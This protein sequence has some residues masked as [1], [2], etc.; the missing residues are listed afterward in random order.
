M[1]ML[2]R[3]VVGVFLICV[4]CCST[5]CVG[6]DTILLDPEEQ[7]G[8][9]VRYFGWDTKGM[10][11]L[12]DDLQ[13]AKWLYQ[14]TQANIMR[15]PIRP[16]ASKPDGSVV[17][18][19]EIESGGYGALIKS[20][21]MAKQVQP[22]VKIF[23]ST[24]LLGEDTFPTWLETDRRGK[25]FEHVVKQPNVE[26]LAGLIAEYFKHLAAEGIKI[27]FLGLNN[28]FGGALTPDD[29]VEL[30]E[31]VQTNL[32]E[33][34]LPDQFK[35]FQWIAGE[36]FGVD[37]SVEYIQ[38]MLEV[39]GAKK[40]ID[41]AGSHFY[42]DYKSGAIEDWQAL[43]SFDVP[44][45]HT[46]VHVRRREQPAENVVALRDGMCIVFKTNQIGC[47]GYIWWQGSADREL[48]GNL[49]RQKMMQSLLH[50]SCVKTSGQ[51]KARDN[52]PKH[53]VAQATRVKDTIWL[54]YFNPSDPIE[55]L[56][57]KL[58]SGEIQS[59]SATCFRGGKN[60]TP[61][62]VSELEVNIDRRN[63]VAAY[64]VPKDSIVVFEIQLKSDP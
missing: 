52:D 46:E 49:V 7:T 2:Y 39:Q 44:T 1:N 54:W 15:I 25:I 56:P 42:P 20:I 18:E 35:Q 31:R 8:A 38:K 29:C 58:E 23:A 24:K 16:Q 37:D 6:Q 17:F 21:K 64:G 19:G 61:E 41:I 10:A 14:D 34:D 30:A 12:S 47:E 36:E 40:F 48:L 59:A 26:K 53:R 43:A 28:E 22:R 33:S 63:Q 50:G 3:Y 11:D 32:S 62:S 60:V 55:Q 57:V 51:Y 27:D 13:S 4:C 9:T 45:W 5:P